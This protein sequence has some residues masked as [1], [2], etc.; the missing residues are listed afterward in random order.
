MVPP[1]VPPMVP[2]LTPSFSPGCPPPS[3]P[4]RAPPSSGCSL[5]LHESSGFG[6]TTVFGL[7]VTF[8]LAAAP[9][10]AGGG[11]AGGGGGAADRNVT[12]SSGGDSSSMCQNEYDDAGGDQR[13]V[14]PDRQRVPEP[15]A[16]GARRR[17]A[18]AR[19]ASNAIVSSS[20]PRRERALLPLVRAIDRLLPGGR[21][22]EQPERFL[23]PDQRQVGHRVRVVRA[24]RHRLLEV[25]DGA[26]RRARRAPCP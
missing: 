10:P 18:C 19:K 7:T 8:F 21:L 14:E 13:A 20:R 4:L 24:Q 3:A 12:L 22:G 25:R 1:G 11:G 9:P 17:S 23:P 26:G 16:A 15:L 5:R 6:C 2:P